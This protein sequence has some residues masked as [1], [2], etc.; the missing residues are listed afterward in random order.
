MYSIAITDIYLT[1]ACHQDQFVLIHALK[2]EDDTLNLYQ[3]LAGQDTHTNS[4]DHTI[5]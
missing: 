3:E 1:V 2:T 5:R 4:I